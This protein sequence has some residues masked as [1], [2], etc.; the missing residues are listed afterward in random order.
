MA[1]VKNYTS[2][3]VRASLAVSTASAGVDGGP[4]AN[5]RLLEISH[6]NFDFCRPVEQLAKPV[7]QLAK[8]VEI[9]TR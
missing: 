6:F 2:R 7:E 3:Q 1:K 4:A 5:A 9:V 8:K